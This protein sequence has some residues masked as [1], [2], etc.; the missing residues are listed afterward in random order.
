[1]RRLRLG[2]PLLLLSIAGLSASCGRPLK[3]SDSRHDDK[4]A[5]AK[6]QAPGQPS[7]STVSTASPGSP[8]SQDAAASAEAGSENAPAKRRGKYPT[9][10]VSPLPGWPKWA[11]DANHQIS[12]LAFREGHLYAMPD[13]SGAEKGALLEIGL[14]GA[15]GSRTLPVSVVCRWKGGPHPDAE[16]LVLDPFTG[17]PRAALMPLESQADA[18]IEIGLPG[19]ELRGTYGPLSGKDN[20]RGIEGVA[21]S[22]DGRTVYLVHE[23]R[24]QL[25]TMARGSQGPAK[26]V[27]RIEGADSLCDIAY[28][29]RGTPTLDDD[30]LLL[31]DRNAIQIFATTLSGEVVG[32]W[33]LDR[34]GV[35]AD[36]DGAPYLI[37]S[38]EGLA[39]ESRESD[40]SLLVYASTDTP[41]DLFPYHRRD[42]KDEHGQ[43]KRRIGMLYR[44]RLPPFRQ[45]QPSGGESE[46]GEDA[47]GL[48]R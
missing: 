44:F 3:G 4:S 5:A 8:G 27:T 2:L 40:G 17:P 1:M 11:G 15:S 46:A 6:T 25:L 43:Y 13:Q 21:L 10:D 29:D 39:I 24:C 12:G 37:V 28:D 9:I 32:R 19:C 16:G 34:K 14:G 20:N 45:A 36:P 18:L 41:P 33:R 26:V 38:F 22:P 48:D 42:D 47:E 31:L 23:T 35:E 7:A 30:R